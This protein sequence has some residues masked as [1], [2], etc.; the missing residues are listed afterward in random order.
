MRLMSHAFADMRRYASFFQ[1]PNRQTAELGVVQELVNALSRSGLRQ[2]VAPNSF[3]PDPPDCTCRNERDSLVAI[4]VTEVVCSCAARC[5]AQGQNVYRE[6][7]GGELRTRIAQQLAAKD[8]KSFHGGPYDEIL[9]CLFTDE[10][11]LSDAR[12]RQELSS[13]TFGPFSKLT[14][15]YL[16]LSYDPGLQSYLVHALS[17]KNT[18]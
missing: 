1:W 6:W 14:G 10:L 11:T 15:A 18:A 8:S 2:L 9:V 13:A 5:V 4:E 16:L 12:V 7:G 17:F 3:D